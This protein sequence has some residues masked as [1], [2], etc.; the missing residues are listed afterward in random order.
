MIWNDWQLIASKTSRTLQRNVVLKILQEIRKSYDSD[1]VHREKEK[2]V[3]VKD[4]L[5]IKT[6][7]TTGPSCTQGLQLELFQFCQRQSIFQREGWICK[8]VAQTDHISGNCRERTL[9]FLESVVANPKY[10][11]ISGEREDIWTATILCYKLNKYYNYWELSSSN[12]EKEP[13][14]IHGSTYIIH[15]QKIF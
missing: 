12:R 15:I 11:D 1:H 3:E 9:F 14:C 4:H 6:S 8:C 7:L 13:D 10:Q 5:L 2:H